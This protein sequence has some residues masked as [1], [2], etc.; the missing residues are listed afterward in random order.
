MMVIVIA[1]FS[2]PIAA[3]LLLLFASLFGGVLQIHSPFWKDAYLLLGT[4]LAVTC[5]YWVGKTTVLAFF[6]TGFRRQLLI[7]V[8]MIAVFLCSFSHWEW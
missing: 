4:S 7:P 3:S 8:A 1:A 6:K 5:L 2:W